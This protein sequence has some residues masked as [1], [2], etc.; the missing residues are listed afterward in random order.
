MT[1]SDRSVNIAVL[2]DYQ[3]VALSAADWSRITERASITVFQ[4]HVTDQDAL[5]ERLAPFDVICVMRERTPLTASLLKR[6]PKLKLIASTGPSNASIR[7]DRY[8][9]TRY[10][11]RAHG[12]HVR[13]DH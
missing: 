9:G 6:L 12:L 13:A 5:A 11:R 10:C 2:D 8:G 7:P 4:D 3:G 1:T